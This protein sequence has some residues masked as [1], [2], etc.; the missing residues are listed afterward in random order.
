[1]T[2]HIKAKKKEIAKTVIMPGD[3]LR[4]E[5]IAK[6]YLENYKLVNSVRGM[7]AYTGIYKGKEVTVMGSGMGM[8]SMGI[9]SYELFKFYDVENIIR[10]GSCGAY[11]PSLKLYDVILATS[12]YSESSYA[13]IQNGTS[14]KII[15][16]SSLLSKKIKDAALN[17]NKKIHEGIIYSSDVFYA[18][19]QR[20]PD[21]VLG[22]EMESFALFHNAKILNKNAACILTVSDHILTKEQTTSEEREKAFTEMMEIALETL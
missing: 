2:P 11:Q 17:L 15:H 1:M 4:A 5:F 19:N 13:Y 7:L 16:P 21:D 6:N 3:P 20:I 10:I 18:E 12:S 8:P 9:Y 14:E 22:I